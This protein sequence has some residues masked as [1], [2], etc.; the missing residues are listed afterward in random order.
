[1]KWIWK[2]IKETFFFCKVS[3][4]VKDEI[5]KA[6]EIIVT[7]LKFWNLNMHNDG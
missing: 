4:Y 3:K 7:L 2:K 5:S 1:M 6:V